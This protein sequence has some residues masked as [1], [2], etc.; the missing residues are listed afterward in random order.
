MIVYY[1]I[2]KLKLDCKIPSG[3]INNLNLLKVIAKIIEK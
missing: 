2:K 1:F 3:E